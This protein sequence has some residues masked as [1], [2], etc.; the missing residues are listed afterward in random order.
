MAKIKFSALVSDMRNKLNGS[1]MSKNR[2][3]SYM[4]NKTTPVNPQTTF[5]QNARAILA[6]TSQAWG[7]LTEAQRNGWKALAQELPFTDIFGDPKTLSG[8]SLYCKLNS[9]LAK[10]FYPFISDAP[11]KEAIPFISIPSISVVTAGGVL[12]SL[13]FNISPAVVPAGTNLIVYATPA[14]NPGVSFVK[15]Q[16]RLIAADPTVVAGVVNLEP[17]WNERF[18]GC[19]VGQ[20]IFVRVALMSI[21]SGQQGQPSEI[22]G[23][24][25]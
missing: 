15:N 4:R 20:K 9:N 23:V 2:Y 8:N 17:F 25:T 5:Q 6:S 7:G 3:G 13:E 19:Q 24:A 22:L 10:G 14:I 21:T 12:S 16:F 11:A 1:V 18:G